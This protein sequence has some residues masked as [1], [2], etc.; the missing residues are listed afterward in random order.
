MIA[1]IPRE[2]LRRKDQPAAEAV[3]PALLARR[4]GSVLR[5][6]RA[7]E[8]RARMTRRRP[9]ERAA[10]RRSCFKRRSSR[11]RRAVPAR[12]AERLG[13]RAASPSSRSTSSER[14]DGEM[15]DPSPNLAPSSSRSP[16]RARSTG[17][18]TRLPSSA[19]AKSRSTEDEEAPTGQS[20]SLLS[21]EERK[22]DPEDE[23]VIGRSRGLS[24]PR[25]RSGPAARSCAAVRPAARRRRR[26][27][28]RSATR[29][30]RGPTRSPRATGWTT[31]RAR[32]C[33]CARR[34]SRRKRARWR[35]SRARRAGCSRAASSSR[36][37]GDRDRA[38]GARRGGARSR[39]VARPGAS[40]GSRADAV[41][42]GPAMPISRRSTPR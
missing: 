15:F 12:P 39:A 31:L 32:R 40:A 4:T 27:R 42:P 26:S 37:L 30:E 14:G 24:R 41:A 1:A 17:S 3:V 7:G 5:A 33:D 25:A 22:Y 20:H 34:G 38:R 9:R 18:S 35:T 13:R 23:T 19:D 16:P 28:L 6:R 8:T 10:P 36:P 21:P 29:R 11:A 2:L